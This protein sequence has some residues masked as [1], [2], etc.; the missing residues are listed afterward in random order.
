MLAKMPS[1]VFEEKFR[2]ALVKES[3]N[4]ISF[5]CCGNFLKKCERLDTIEKGFA[6][7]IP[8]FPQV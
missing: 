7:I 2:H 5:D 6:W 4:Q 3:C 1:L 8:A